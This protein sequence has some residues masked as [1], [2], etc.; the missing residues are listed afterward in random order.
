MNA[1]NLLELESLDRARRAT[2]ENERHPHAVRHLTLEWLLKQEPGMPRAVAEYQVAEAEKSLRKAEPRF[3]HEYA[4]VRD[5]L[6]LARLSPLELGAR[7][8]EARDERYQVRRAYERT[9]R[10]A[11]DTSGFSADSTHASVRPLL[12]GQLVLGDTAYVLHR[13]GVIGGDDVDLIMGPQVIVL[14]RK[15]GNWR[16]VPSESLL[17]W[18]NASGVSVMCETLEDSIPHTSLIGGAVVGVIAPRLRVEPSA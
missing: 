13:E 10:C 1:A 12:I 7:F 15:G 8:L 14:H 6:T 2:L 9:P 3:A 16:I 4:N 17:R 11:F 18:G 5:T